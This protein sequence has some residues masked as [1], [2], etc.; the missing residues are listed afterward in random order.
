KRTMTVIEKKGHHDSVY[1]NAAQILQGI[2]TEK[3]K[4]QL[5]V[6]YGDGSGPLVL[7]FKDEY[8]QRV[9]CELAFSALKHQDVLEEILLDSCAY[10]C[11]SIL[12]EL[13][14]LLVVMLYDL[15]DRK[16]QA[17]QIFN[18]EEPVAEV[19][20]VEHHLYSFRTTLAAALA[21]CHIKHD[22]LSIQYTLP[23]T[24]RKQEQR[25]SA[26]PSCVWIN[27]F[28]ISLEDVFMDVKKKGFT[29]AES[30]S[31]LDCCTYC[32]DQHC[33]DVLVCPSSLK[34]ELLNLDLFA[35]FRLLM[36]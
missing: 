17:R 12:D 9:S 24:I 6:R 35:D 19:R 15:Q 26:L 8:S 21:R 4:D 7:T 22:A 16:F 23:E 14:S 30:A 3:P 32:I 33:Y 31:D 13:T 36:Q 29:R 28:K 1:V 20:K 11:Q 5:L 34:E 10:P 25:V 2:H 18:E 27:T